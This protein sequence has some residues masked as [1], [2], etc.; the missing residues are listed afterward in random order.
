MCRIKDS[1]SVLIGRSAGWVSPRLPAACTFSLVEN[2]VI[3]KGERKKRTQEGMC[4]GKKTAWRERLRKVESRGR[5]EQRG[6]GGYG[7]GQGGR[8]GSGSG[9]RR[10]GGLAVRE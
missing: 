7:G 5:V 2:G 10:R 8:E 6:E 9:R 4:R 1:P 3:E